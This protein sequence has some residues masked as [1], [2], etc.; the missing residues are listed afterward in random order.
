[1]NSVVKGNVGELLLGGDNVALGYYNSGEKTEEKFVQN[2]RHEKYLDIMYKTGDLVKEDHD[3]RLLFFIGRNDDQIKVMGHR[4]ELGEIES[5]VSSFMDVEECAV[6]HRILKGYP[7]IGCFWSGTVTP[8]QLRSR[9]SKFLPSYMM[10]HK[11]ISVQSLPKNPN[12]KI[13]RKSLK[14]LK[15]W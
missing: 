13:D 4:I 8:E 12:G 7:E 11:Y 2:P 15:V 6:V 10:P 3:S 9:L 14:E 5:V 1:M